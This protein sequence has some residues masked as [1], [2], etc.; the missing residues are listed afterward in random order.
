MA[1]MAIDAPSLKRTSTAAELETPIAKKQNLGTLRHHKPTW[2]LNRSKKPEP[3]SQDGKSIQSLLTRSIALALDAVGF[4]AAE[5]VAMESF[6]AE[7]EECTILTLFIPRILTVKLII[8]DMTDFLANVRLSMLSSRRT[9][10]VPQDFLQSLH[11]H[12]L[13]L[14]SLTPH[15][16]P[17]VPPS[18]SQISIDVDTAPEEKQSEFPFLEPTLIG[19]SDDAESRSYVPKHFPA[20]PSKHTYK[21]TPEVP[22]RENEPRKIRELAMEEGRL[23][24]EALRRF[25]SAGSDRTFN[26]TS[27]KRPAANSARSRREGLWQET[28]SAVAEESGIAP[29]I[30]HANNRLGGKLPEGSNSVGRWHLSSAVNADSRYWRRNAS[31]EGSHSG[32]A[33]ELI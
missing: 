27:K 10:T 6:R 13:S 4:E 22:E 18:R 21:M 1:P 26:T 28:M 33:N 3:P 23:A 32:Q 24:E 11:T 29:E 31:T 17:P 14:R 9:Q 12:H 19:I 8:S 20:F 30:T 7:V 16:D 5:P 2:D 15:L 25:L